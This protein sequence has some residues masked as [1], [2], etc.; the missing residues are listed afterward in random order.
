MHR[1]VIILAGLLLPL[2]AQAQ[3]PAPVGGD[4]SNTT[5]KAT[6]TSTARKLGDRAADVIRAI[7][8]GS[9]IWDGAHDVAPCVN[10]AISAAAAR[11]GNWVDVPAGSFPINSEVLLQSSGIKLRGQGHN[12]GVNPTTTLVWNGGVGGTMVQIG[13]TISGTAVWGAGIVGIDL[14]CNPANAATGQARR[15]FYTVNSWGSE[16]DIFVNEPFVNSPTTAGLNA[17]A[18]EIDGNANTG[19]YRIAWSM[20]NQSLPAGAAISPIGTYQ[21][22]K[23]PYPA[24][25]FIH[26]AKDAPLS[27]ASFDSFVLYGTQ[28]SGVPVQVDWS[29]HL[30][31]DVVVL[32]L[33]ASASPPLLGAGMV[34]NNARTDLTAAL[35]PGGA[36]IREYQASLPVVVEGTGTN[37]TAP[38]G[39]IIEKND[40]GNGVPSPIFNT[41][42][43]GRW[44][45]DLGAFYQAKI[46]DALAIANSSSYAAQLL[47]APGGSPLRIG[48]G[49]G[50][51]IAQI[52]GPDGIA[53]GYWRL[54]MDKLGAGN[55]DLTFQNVGFGAGT[56]AA[57]TFKLIGASTNLMFSDA[58]G[59]INFNGSALKGVSGIQV[60]GI[61]GVSC[62]AGSVSLTTLVVTGGVVTHC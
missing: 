11:A 15:G 51:F 7:D 21:L 26:S 43:T 4:M 6:G 12:Y 8:Y 37:I 49:V 2:A 61:A 44:S 32:H 38:A 25:V 59:G 31:F 1:A 40:I 10:A 9:C 3:P 58:A 27:N 42:S 52:Y 13:T 60:N 22:D 36:T 28:R 5:V 18:A 55:Y 34:I 14:D 24:G 46:G 35:A 41:G 53:A 19:K 16:V 54:T 30:T 62:A 48:D 50:N 39:T 17:V 56:V 45:D 20:Q 29:D 57:P 23:L 33:G 47:A